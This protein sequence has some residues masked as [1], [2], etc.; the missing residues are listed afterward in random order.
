MNRTRP[1]IIAAVLL[2][3]S[4]PVLSAQ[5]DHSSLADVARRK[6]AHKAKVVITNDDIPPVAGAGAQ[7]S[8]SVK[9]AGDAAASA[10]PKEPHKDGAGKSQPAPETQTRL[11]E[12]LAERRNLQS[13]IKHLEKTMAE[14]TDEPARSNLNR[15]LQHSRQALDRNQEQIDQ[16]RRDKSAPTD[17]PPAGQAGPQNTAP[18]R[19]K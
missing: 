3:A 5:S 4:T 7:P 1:W 18:P 16:L 2:C 6:P 15:V 12:L 9:A 19:P 17:V 11:Q 14:R 10:S 8:S 13:V